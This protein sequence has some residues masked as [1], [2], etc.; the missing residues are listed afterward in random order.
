VLGRVVEFQ[1]LRDAE[2]LLRGKRLVE[3]ADVMRVQVVEDQHDLLRLWVMH[4]HQL[5]DRFGPVHHRAPL[6]DLHVAPPGQRLKEEEKVGHSVA[7]L[8]IVAPLRLTGRGWDRRAAL[9]YQLLADLIHA[10]LGPV[11]VVGAGVE[12]QDLFHLGDKLAAVLGRN[13]PLFLQ[14]RLRF[15]FLSVWRTVS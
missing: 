11:R 13:A 3:R 9:S 1:P 14:P 15:V 2:R 8:F 7:D 12:F 10:D 4:V 5:P 6:G